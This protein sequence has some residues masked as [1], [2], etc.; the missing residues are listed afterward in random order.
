MSPVAAADGTFRGGETLTE[1]APGR[2]LAYCLEGPVGP[3]AKASS[4]WS[5]SPDTHPAA[6]VTVEGRFEPKS[7]AVRVF[8]WPVAQLMLRRTTDPVLREL[9]SYRLAGT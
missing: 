2:A 8:V 1:F 9:E 5:T 4:R 7:G 6:V 3:F